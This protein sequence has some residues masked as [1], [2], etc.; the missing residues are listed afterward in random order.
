[1]GFLLSLPL[2][3]PPTAASAVRALLRACARREPMCFGCL[4]PAPVRT[5]GLCTY[6]SPEARV[7]VAPC[8]PTDK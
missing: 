1:M 2:A 8:H 3:R 5:P 7:L 4:P 6:D